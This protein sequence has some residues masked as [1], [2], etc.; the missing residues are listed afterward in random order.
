MSNAPRESS[1]ASRVR[2][3]RSV[4]ERIPSP[5]EVHI[6]VGPPPIAHST[7]GA[8]IRSVLRLVV[9]T[10]RWIAVAIALLV[11]LVVV[12]VVDLLWSLLAWLARR[13]SLLLRRL[14]W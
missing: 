2:V 7:L 6:A 13:L 10:L 3:G 14:P 1:E 11:W 5:D 4:N 12:P 8:R 9:L